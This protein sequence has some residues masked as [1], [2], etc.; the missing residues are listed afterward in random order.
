MLTPNE[1]KIIWLKMLNRPMSQPDKIF[2][3]RH[4]FNTI[5]ED[6]LCGKRNHF[7]MEPIRMAENLR[8]FLPN[9]T[10]LAQGEHFSGLTS[11]GKLKCSTMGRTTRIQSW[12]SKTKAKIALHILH[13]QTEHSHNSQCDF[14]TSSFSMAT[15][16]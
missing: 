2:T 16:M 9:N 12:P 3:A 1:P 7:L 10:F 14:K 6:I 15:V 5:L 13:A 11:T 8:N 4:K